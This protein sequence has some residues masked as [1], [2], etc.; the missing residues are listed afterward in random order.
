MPANSKAATRPQSKVLTPPIV[1][2]QTHNKH[3][4][5]TS[6][7]DSVH[8]EREAPLQ[9]LTSPTMALPKS[10]WYHLEMMRPVLA[11]T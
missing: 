6:K 7:G 8:S 11:L 4:K 3:D 2:S 10:P 9:V 1:K 5:N